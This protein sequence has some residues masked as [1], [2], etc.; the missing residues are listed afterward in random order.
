MIR[1]PEGGEANGEFSMKKIIAVSA[2]LVLVAVV[3]GWAFRDEPV[4]SLRVGSESYPVYM[5]RW[6]GTL[7]MISAGGRSV[8]TQ[9]SPE[10]EK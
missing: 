8:I 1:R 7:H 10:E 9:I 6:T 3:L 4:G 2:V 5:N